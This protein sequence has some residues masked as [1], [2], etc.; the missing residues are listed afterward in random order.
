MG[1]ASL[2]YYSIWPYFVAMGLLLVLIHSPFF[3]LADS[4]PTDA[5]G[6]VA[7]VD[8]LRGF[9]AMAVVFQHVAVYHNYLLTAQWLYPQSHFYFLLGEVGVSFFFMIT[10][11]LF[12]TQLLRAQG[13]PNWRK[14]YVGRAF[15]IL[16]LYWFAVILVLAGVLS[17]T[18]FHLRVPEV[19]FVSEILRWSAGGLFEA[20]PINGYSETK[21]LIV[22]VIWTLRFE[23]IFYFSL[24]L[25]AIFVSLRKIGWLFPMI[26][27]GFFLIHEALA[28]NPTT[29]LYGALFCI[30]MGAA[31]LKFVRPHLE[32]SG[33]WA[34]LA[35]LAL[36]VIAFTVAKTSYSP[37]PAL[38]LGAVFFLI[39]LGTDLFGI[40]ATRPARRMGNISYGLYLLQGPV[41][42]G[43]LS[44]S[45]VRSLDTVSPLGHWAFA[46][47]EGVALISLATLAHVLIE[48]PGIA[49]GRRFS[50][51]HAPAIKDAGASLAS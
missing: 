8:G 34:S 1:A 49:L 33:P 27:L 29:F 38:L 28:P 50:G 4:P 45:A 19:Q 40:L 22:A 32:I 25:L 37:V 20:I 23:W 7:N 46:L 24:P 15:R 42:A 2:D 41:F 5:K 30:G 12:Y 44:F 13:F 9:L 36:L 18:G 14:L 21:R 11:Y 17:H 35:A 31:V 47:L 16:P 48:R 39:V 6:R 10:G 51:T 3:R 26:M 43:L